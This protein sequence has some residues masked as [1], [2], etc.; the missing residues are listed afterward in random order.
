MAPI[1]PSPKPASGSVI[2]ETSVQESSSAE[3]SDGNGDN[4]PSTVSPEKESVP[5]NSEKKD[6]TSR[7]KYVYNDRTKL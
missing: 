3:N 5:V 6:D 7:P 4:A 1:V 2:K